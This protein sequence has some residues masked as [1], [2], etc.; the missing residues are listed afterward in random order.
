MRLALP[1]SLKQA[2]TSPVAIVALFSLLGLIGI[3]N[4]AMWRDEL[5]TWLIVRDS[6]SLLEMLGR[7]NYQGHT[8][9]WG[10]CLAAV[11]QITTAPV[12]MQLFHL[13]LGIGAMILFWR[14]SPF[15]YRDKVLF[16]FGTV[17][18]YQYLLI[19]RPYVLG[20]I[21]LFGFC[22]AF[23]SRRR[24]Y[25]G[26]A[27]L[28]ALLANSNAYALF[29]SAALFVMLA[30]EFC[31]S[32]A[33]RSR[34]WQQAHWLDLALSLLI[35]IA[36]YC[37]AAYI[38]APPPDSY[39]HGG[40][41]AWFLEWDPRHFLRGWGRL[42]AGYFLVIPS[43]ERWL[44]L[45]VCGLI[46]LAIAAV[47][48]L[49]LTRK[50][51]ALTFYSVANLELLAF[52]YSRHMEGGLR[53]FVHFYLILIATLWLAHHF[54][55]SDWLPRRLSLPPQWMH[56]AQRWQPRLLTM[57]LLVHFCVGIAGYG[58]SFVVPFSG[59]RAVA[60]YIR[61]SGWQNELI[62]ASRDAH[63]APIAGYLNRRLYYPEL[64]GMG[65]FTLFRE[66]RQMG[67]PHGEVLAQTYALLHN[68]KQRE[69]VLLLLSEEL[70]ATDPRLVLEPIK[71]FERPHIDTERYYYLYWATL[72]DRP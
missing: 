67:V 55:E 36:S 10:L 30:V 37:F 17:P 46:M 33:Q 38:L 54:P 23:A 63:M 71:A 70:N 9:L 59:G 44:D 14:F 19:A 6:D 11:Q 34:Y 60:H 24:T 20:L 42:F 8:A 26:L 57:I 62:V 50:P 35:V 22:A 65:S 41:G 13:A 47:F 25:L 72:R 29:I 21:S 31:W 40:Q 52:I 4:H 56:I 15:R 32:P 39:N 69:R 51:I 58:R 12:A 64:Q 2:V 18:F 1:K 16:T 48:V 45:A 61:Q 66:Q 7:I 68:Q 28:L 27:V 5:N 53:H 43:H 3:L 49:R